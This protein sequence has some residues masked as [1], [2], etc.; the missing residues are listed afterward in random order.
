MATIEEPTHAERTAPSNEDF[1]RAL[2]RGW[3]PVAY[4]SD[5]ETPVQARLLGIELVAFRDERG[6]PR[7]ASN[8]CPHRGASLS[9]GR[10]VGDAIECPYHGWQ[11]DGG[12][13]RC[14]R[15]PAVGPDGATPRGARLKTHQ[16]DERYGVVWATLSADPVG[17]VPIFEEV[18][19]LDL[20][21]DWIGAPPWDVSCNVCAAVENFRDVA[22]L[23]FV[24][25]ETMGAI[26]PEVEPL[27]P[28]RRGFHAYLARIENRYELDTSDETWAAAHRG[29][30]QI[31]YH[32]IAPSA[33]AIVVGSSEDA[34]K[35]TVVF[36]VAPTSLES[37]RWFF[38]GANTAGYPTSA[39]EALELGRAIT[40]EDAAILEGVRPRGFEGL[41][42]QVHC[43]ADA[44]TL[45]YREAFMSFVREAA[46]AD[47]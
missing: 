44:Y 5:L 10:V 26:R 40:N 1:A 9:M 38:I 32:A 14:Q 6:R 30:V 15:I 45:K 33:V 8:Q 21:S 19:A 43:V 23:P 3:F 39:E 35:R 29:T 7:V 13:G 36:A 31:V 24:H 4:S 46:A 27:Q 18:E 17:E 47:E 37:T 34:G 42:E 28:V 16:A 20:A 12:T 41:F 2:R 11:W 22:H 25:R